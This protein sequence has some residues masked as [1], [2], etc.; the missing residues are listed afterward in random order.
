MSLELKHCEF[1]GR[2]TSKPPEDLCFAEDAHKPSMLVIEEA[3]CCLD[4]SILI[5]GDATTIKGT[6]SSIFAVT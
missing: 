3:Y 6:E 2:A 4:S 1:E 5:K